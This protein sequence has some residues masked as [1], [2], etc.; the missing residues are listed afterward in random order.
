M[1]QTIDI[2]VIENNSQFILSQ[3]PEQAKDEM[4]TFL[5]YLV[6]KYNISIENKQKQPKENSLIDKFSAFRTG[7]PLGYKFNREEA[8]ER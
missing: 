8:N 7:L 2:N 6:Y 3:L 1:L 5:Q 4:N